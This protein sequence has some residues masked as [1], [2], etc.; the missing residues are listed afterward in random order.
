MKKY[1]FSDGFERLS[2]NWI[3][4]G[5]R[6]AV[7]AQMHEFSLKR[8]GISGK[9]FYNDPEAYVKGILQTASDFKLDIPDIVWDAYN[10]EAEA[11]GVKVLYKENASPALDQTP[12]INNEIDLSKLKI[13]DPVSSGRYPWVMNC[14]EIFKELTGFSSAHTF[15]APMSLACLLVGYQNLIMNIYSNPKFVHKILKVLT[16]EVIAPYINA[17]FT[18]F[19]NCP[20]A[21]G[22][23]ALSSLPFLTQDMVKNFSV[24]YIL[25]LRELCGDKISVRNWW[26]DSYSKSLEEFWALKMKVGNG[27]LEVQDPDL[28]K[29]GPEKVSEYAVRHNLP[30]IL[31]VDQNLLA[32][33]SPE[34]IKE[35][36]KYYI[37]IGSREK[38]LVIYL[39]NLNFKTP[40]ENIRVAVETIR[41]YGKYDFDPSQPE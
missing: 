37:K 22:S 36:I 24:P 20:M 8:S 9:K 23:D 7:F 3:G 30:L 28:Y 31:G 2:K 4:L 26:G 32:Q 16:E 5:D 39:C 19:I 29:L 18:K 25:R 38:K 13:P 6:P 27:V 21:D 12:L 1:D 35:R 15:C 33:G 40:D 10:L 14:L 17:V 34:E 11:L 41:K